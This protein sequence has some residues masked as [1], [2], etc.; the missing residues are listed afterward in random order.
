MLVLF[1][2]NTKFDQCVFLYALTN[3]HTEGRALAWVRA[4]LVNDEMMSPSQWKSSFI[5][6]RTVFHHDFGPKH[7]KIFYLPSI[8]LTPLGSG[9][10]S[11]R[12][13][14]PSH[15]LTRR[16]P[17]LGNTTKAG[18]VMNRSPTCTSTQGLLWPSDITPHNNNKSLCNDCN[19]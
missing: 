18:L 12:F 11:C 15:R 17:S 16:T 6:K 8:S 9:I 5:S 10:S 3:K 13:T 1:L 4:S 2:S 19:C 14:V 7:K